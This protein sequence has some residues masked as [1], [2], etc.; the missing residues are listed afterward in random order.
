MEEVWHLHCVYREH[1][2]VVVVVDQSQP[3]IHSVDIGQYNIEQRIGSDVVEVVPRKFS[4]SVLRPGTCIRPWNRFSINIYLTQCRSVR[5]IK[6]IAVINRRRLATDN[7]NSV[8]QKCTKREGDEVKV[9]C[10][11]NLKYLYILPR[12]PFVC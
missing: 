5:L 3:A 7:N 4:S 8:D 11:R 12:V 9:E 2:A 1:G 10:F 6:K